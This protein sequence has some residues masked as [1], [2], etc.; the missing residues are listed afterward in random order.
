MPGHHFG[1]LLYQVIVQKPGEIVAGV[2]AIFLIFKAKLEK[3]EKFRQT[4]APQ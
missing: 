1:T 4:N 2:L 3:L